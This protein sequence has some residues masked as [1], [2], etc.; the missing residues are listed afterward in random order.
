MKKILC[1]IMV[2]IMA[3]AAAV[4]SFAA[5]TEYTYK[6]GDSITAVLDT[7][8]RTLTLTGTGEMYD[9][10]TLSRPGWY[11][12]KSKPLTVTVGEGITHVGS[13]AFADF[14]TLTEIELPDTLKTV[15]D[16]AFYHCIKLTSLDFPEGVES[17]G[18][19]TLSE[20]YAL[21]SVTL[22]ESIPEIPDG[23]FRLST[24]LN[25]VVMPESCEEIG[26][27]AF[28][29]CAYIKSL[30]LPANLKRIGE[31]AFRGCNGIASMT[32]PYGLEYI[33]NSAFYSL[34]T[35]KTLTIP[36]T[37]THIGDT[38]FC[39]T[40][41]YNALPNG[42]NLV[43]GIAITYKGTASSKTLTLPEGTKTVSP[44]VCGQ[45][46]NV[47]EV[48]IPSTVTKLSEKAFYNLT[49]LYSVTVPVSVTEIGDYALGYYNSSQAAPAP[50]YPFTVYGAAGSAAE[51]YAKENGFDFV[52]VHKSGAYA[53]YPVCTEGG[54]ALC[55]CVYCGEIVSEKI[56]LPKDHTYTQSISI[57]ATCT[58]DG[59]TYRTCTLCSYTDILSTSSATGHTPDGEGMY[60]KESTCA[61][62]GLIYKLCSVCEQPFDSVQMEKLP[63][64][65]SEEK[66][67]IE[68]ATCKG[69]GIWAIACTECSC[70]LERGTIE[71]TGHRAGAFTVLSECDYQT[72]TLGIRIK[73]CEYCGIV[74]EYK[75]FMRGDMNGDGKINSRD[76]LVFKKTLQGFF[77][78][79][80]KFLADINKDNKINS[81]DSASFKHIV[82]GD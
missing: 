72:G 17:I 53:Q 28:L 75:T 14:L 23:M 4:P 38:A 77:G 6:C 44:K 21:L 80:E 33:G 52:C 59:M 7:T 30:E 20:C 5:A 78:E 16:H 61:E 79:E 8:A 24:Y 35:L 12:Q 73:E 26:I 64:T 19:Y 67:V 37:V 54:T 45:I 42:F 49:S 71:A 63:H 22:P 60:I 74:V 68:E 55:S 2:L 39:S 29:S 47:T 25:T 1:L 65:P 69:E 34:S 27:Q 31:E 43:N 70:E 66:T 48:V 51:V 58:D 81:R 82:I 32:L 18:A 15:G 50:M 41:W 11:S 57:P 62:N 13:Y 3:A 76:A 9:Y 40:P 46:T 56:I 10:T 36:E